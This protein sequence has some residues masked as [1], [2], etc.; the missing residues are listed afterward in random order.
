MQSRSIVSPAV[1]DVVAGG[2]GRIPSPAGVCSP[3]SALRYGESVAVG[4]V[5]RIC[6][7][8]LGGGV[9]LCEVGRVA[10][11]FVVPITL[12]LALFF[13]ASRVGQSLDHTS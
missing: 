2:V 12:S 1:V 13:C 7:W 4:A 3:V 9:G 10:V 11:L 6:D 5:G 8:R